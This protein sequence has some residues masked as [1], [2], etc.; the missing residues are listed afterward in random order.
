M[1]LPIFYYPINKDDDRST[2]FLLPIYGAS[3]VRGQSLSNAF[4]WAID[5]S[6]D[7]T[8]THDWYSKTGQ[9]FG[10]EYRV[11]ARRRQ[12]RQRRRQP[13][14][15]ARGRLSSSRR[16][17]AKQHRAAQQ[18]PDARRPV[19]GAR[20]GLHARANVNYTSSLAVQQRYQ[21]DVLQTNNRTRNDRR[22]RHRQ[23][24][25]STCSARRSRRTTP[26][27]TRTA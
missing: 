5:R 14:Q 2:G 13:P 27:T 6:Q 22:Q 23:L 21:Q 18:L 25:R 1:Y 20:A 17:R 8:F 16:H 26:S 3:T 11:R 12:P 7:A 9:G 24:V 4:F 15:R 19:A 10:G